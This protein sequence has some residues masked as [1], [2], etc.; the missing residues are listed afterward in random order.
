MKKSRRKHH[1][2]RKPYGRLWSVDDILNHNRCLDLLPPSLPHPSPSTLTAL[3]SSETRFPGPVRALCRRSSATPNLSLPP[4]P[5][6]ATPTPA[7][8][9]RSPTRS[10]TA[11]AHPAI[12]L[13]II[14]C[15]EK[16]CVFTAQADPAR[17]ARNRGVEGD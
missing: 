14:M 11:R 12:K 17:H 13:C 9:Q 10:D 5:A 1:G 16:D 6:R 15:V 8:A 7:R 4:T 2:T 3:L